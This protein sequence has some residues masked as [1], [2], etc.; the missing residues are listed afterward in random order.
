MYFLNIFC[1]YFLLF[2]FFV[3]TIGLLFDKRQYAYVF[4]SNILSSLLFCILVS[5]VYIK[6][7]FFIFDNIFLYAILGF[8]TNFVYLRYIISKNSE[9]IKR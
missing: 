1:F 9:P 5:I 6:K 2:C 7:E 4:F 8:L 3:V